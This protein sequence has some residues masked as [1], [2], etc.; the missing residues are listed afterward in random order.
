MNFSIVFENTGDGL[1]FETCSSE[2]AEVLAY[3][4]ECLNNK[5]LNKFTIPAAGEKIQKAITAID[6]SLLETNKWI[7]ELVDNY[8]TRYE[9][10][11]YLNQEVLNKLHSDWVNSQSLAYDIQVKRKKYN[12]ALTESIHDMFPDEIPVTTL[13]T[14][15]EKLG[16]KK[17]YDSIN[18]NIHNLE[19]LFH[20]IPCRV[21][22]Q[23]WVE[24]N[25]PFSKTLLTNNINNF[26]LSFHHLGRTLYNK[27]DHFD[28]DLD[29]DDENSY[30]Q[31]L[32]FVTLNLLNPQT[33]PLSKEYVAW[34][35]KHNR[36][37]S[38]DRFNIGNLKDLGKRLTDYRKIIFRN[39]LQNNTF[40]IQLTKG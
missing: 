15:V 9:L 32:G 8:V 4:V 29:F 25:N 2:T 31:L 26:S 21:A 36:V 6:L 33:I 30:D 16:Y 22:D 38:G 5:N 11:E 28:T 14:L 19:F 18:T 35:N 12:S 23:S 10:E 39:S 17:T 13:G 37:P 1:P 40:S 20:E 7:Y 3:Y 34:C 27:F 24:F